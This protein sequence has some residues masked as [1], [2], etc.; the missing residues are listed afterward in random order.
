MRA[1]LRDAVPEFLIA[2][3]KNG[4]VCEKRRHLVFNCPPI[5]PLL[6][7]SPSYGAKGL[8]Q[9]SSLPSH[10]PSSNCIGADDIDVAI[11]ID[12]LGGAVS[13]WYWNMLPPI[14]IKRLIRIGKST[15]MLKKHGRCDAA[16]G[17]H[18]N[19]WRSQSCR[20]KPGHP[21][22]G[23]ADHNCAKRVPRSHGCGPQIDHC[24][25]FMASTSR[26]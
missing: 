13:R 23:Y 8:S 18:Q 4:L 26:G 21:P 2:N 19:G 10:P 25:V 14:Q 20:P 24:G 12:D 11:D 17:H 1:D 5:E 7:P 15:D 6:H 9:F 3:R 22:P 16:G